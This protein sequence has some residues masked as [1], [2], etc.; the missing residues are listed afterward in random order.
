MPGG[1][2][3]K[4]RF[5]LRA[6]FRCSLPGMLGEAGGGGSL[7]VQGGIQLPAGS[8]E[9]MLASVASQA[10]QA[11]RRRQPPLRWQRRSLELTNESVLAGK[12]LTALV[13]P[14]APVALVLG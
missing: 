7:L 9:R 12:S 13:A 14:R 8:A 4:V 6:V 3:R 5:G 2:G 10:A 11:S 1:I